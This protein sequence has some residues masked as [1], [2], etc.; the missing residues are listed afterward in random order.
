MVCVFFDVNRLSFGRNVFRQ[1]FRQIHDGKREAASLR[2]CEK[3]GGSSPEIADY[4]II[5]FFRRSLAVAW[6]DYGFR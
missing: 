4:P 5:N 2:S 1:S 6:V 3:S